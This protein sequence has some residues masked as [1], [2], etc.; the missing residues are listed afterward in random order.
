VL[1]KL[2]LLSILMGIV[3]AFV[4]YIFFFFE[5]YG[6]EFFWE[7]LPHFFGINQSVTLGIVSPLWVILM[8]LTGGL[9]VGIITKASKVHPMLLLQEIEEIGKSGRYGLLD[10]IVGMIRGLVALVFGGSIGPEGPITGAVAALGTWF[11]ERA[12]LSK[13]EV[14]VCLNAA[15]SG[16]FGGFFNTSF[17]WPLIL[18]EGGLE[19]GKLSWKL[20]LPAI[21]AG[22]IG[23]GLFFVLTGA[24]F[25]GLFVVPPVPGFDFVFL[26][27]AAILGL[28]GSLL[29]MLFVFLFNLLKR[30]TKPWEMRRPIELALLAGLFLGVVA[31]GF[32][33]VLFDGGSVNSLTLGTLIANAAGIGTPLLAMYSFMKI[34]V[35]TVCLALGWAGGIFFPTFFIGGAMG[36][37]I[38]QLFPFI[39][40]AICMSCV[41]VGVVMP[42]TKLPLTISIVIALAFG[43]RLSGVIAVAAVTSY[44]FAYSVHL[45]FGDEHGKGAPPNQS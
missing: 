23:A 42:V 39:P 36:L 24:S 41:M 4:L 40:L 9:L 26:I 10:G 27:Y 21:L 19:S 1:F 12:N 31:S 8:T 18:M 35:T 2:S 3:G 17:G 11:A 25:M 15:V 45:K 22:S 30:L 5:H 14:M 34:A 29:G 16:M 44:L 13:P 32:P 33:L 7:I 28:V 20:I 38:N 37:A 6:I 43:I